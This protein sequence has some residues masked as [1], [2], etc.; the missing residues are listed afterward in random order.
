[1]QKLNL[2]ELSENFIRAIGQ[3]WMLIT[4]GTPEHFNTMTASWGCVGWLWNRPVAV[5]FIRPERYTYE[6][7][8]NSDHFTLAF[9]GEEH[10]QIHTVCGSQSGRAV[11]KVAA[12]GLQPILTELGHVTFGQARLTLDCQKLYADT[13]KP[14]NFLSQIPFRWYG[15]AEGGYHKMYIAEILAAYTR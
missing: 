8:E 5:A 4:A 6:F 14:E 13:F 3:E 7:V 9:L 11:D 12:T 10:R 2:T 1:M 15:G